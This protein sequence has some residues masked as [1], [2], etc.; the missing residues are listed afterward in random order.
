MVKLIQI[1]KL[2]LF[3]FLIN[4]Y[5]EAAQ[6]DIE[7]SL[8]YMHSDYEGD[9]ISLEKASISIRESISD[10]DG[11]R[12]HLFFKLEAEDNFNENHIDQLYAKYKGWRDH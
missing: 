9:N 4:V 11:D 5:A 6:V 8:E 1:K 7:G 10:Q 2:L 3:L 12:L